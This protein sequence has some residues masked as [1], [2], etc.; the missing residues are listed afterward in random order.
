MRKSDKKFRN[1]NKLKQFDQNIS[2]IAFIIKLLSSFFT[3]I[4]SNP[5]IRKT[6]LNKLKITHEN[7]VFYLIRYFLILTR[8]EKR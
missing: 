4:I 6:F 5:N 7:F 3:K 8:K 2:K 1:N